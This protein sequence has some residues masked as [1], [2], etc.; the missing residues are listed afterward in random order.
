MW[1]LF[2]DTIGYF[3]DSVPRSVKIVL[4][5]LI[6]AAAYFFGGLK[7][8]IYGV[9]SIFWVA[10]I[11]LVVAH[12]IY[13]MN[14]KKKAREAYVPPLTQDDQ[15]D[16]V[17]FQEAMQGEPQVA[18]EQTTIEPTPEPEQD[19]TKQTPPPPQLPTA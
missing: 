12:I 18:P 19:S 8:V 16:V 5:A 14:E 7:G 9:G 10:F 2:W 11:F 15:E 4:L 1:Q 6:A 3:V 17:E 13:V